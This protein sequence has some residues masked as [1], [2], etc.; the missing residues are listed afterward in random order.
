MPDTSIKKVVGEKAPGIIVKSG[1]YADNFKKASTTATLP[2]RREDNVWR[3]K[4]RDKTNLP[5]LLLKNRAPP[6]R[7]QREEKNQNVVRSKGDLRTLEGVTRGLEELKEKTAMLHTPKSRGIS[8]ERE[9]RVSFTNPPLGK[10]TFL[11]PFDKN[12]LC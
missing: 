1:N 8:L 6:P 10:K 2:S 5:R 4:R 7:K 3:G 12:P 11:K 9:T